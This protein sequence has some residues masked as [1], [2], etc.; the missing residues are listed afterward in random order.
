MVTA[1]RE[2]HK[3]DPAY[4]QKLAVIREETVSK[5]SA[6]CRRG[7]TFFVLIVVEPYLYTG[8]CTKQIRLSQQQQNFMMAVTP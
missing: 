8:Q 6:V 3:E 5:D 1:W 4:N 2:L 7:S